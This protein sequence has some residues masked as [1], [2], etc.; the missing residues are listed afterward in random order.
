MS[1]KKLKAVDWDYWKHKFVTTDLS[2]VDLSKV[3]DAPALQSLKNKAHQESWAEQ[4]KV[5]KYQASTIAVQ[6]ATAQQ[7]IEQTQQLVD[8]AAL[9]TQHLQ[10]SKGLK[11]IAS[12]RL[13]Q[14]H[15]DESQ[16]EKLSA[17]DLV[18][19]IQAAAAI[20]RTAMGLA[21][22]RVEV[23]VKVDVSALTDDQLDRLA[24]GEDPAHVLN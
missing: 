15:K 9:I 8:A 17:K 4:R 19:W 1:R 6:S 14:I 2:L 11:S 5:F 21:N 22:D 24:K 7:A 18:S 3:P 12:K 13:Q 23:N 10:L 16:I 20:D